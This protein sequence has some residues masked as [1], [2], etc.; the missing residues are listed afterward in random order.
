METLLEDGSTRSTN[1]RRTLL[2]KLQHEFEKD[3][4]EDETLEK[5]TEAIPQAETVC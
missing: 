5:M 3:K 2:K 4:E 1:F